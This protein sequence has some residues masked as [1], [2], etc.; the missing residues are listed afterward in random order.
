MFDF[1]FLVFFIWVVVVFKFCFGFLV[2]FII[3]VV[4]MNDI[5]V[6]RKILSN[7]CKNLFLGVFK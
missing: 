7:M 5:S 1:F 4:I 6:V 3:K 2:N